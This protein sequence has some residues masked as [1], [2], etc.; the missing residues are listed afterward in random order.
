MATP[1]ALQV[2]SGVVTPVSLVGTSTASVE[3]IGGSVQFRSEAPW[4]VLLTAFWDPTVV[5]GR[6]FVHTLV[7]D[8]FPLH[9]EMIDA[10]AL[11]AVSGGRQILRENTRFAPGALSSLRAEVWQDSKK[12]VN[13]LSL[14]LAFR[15]MF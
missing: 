12:P 6:R 7:S 8:G 13:L 15:P 11:I 2:P 5:E 10:D 1:K 9:S 14:S 3:A 4:E